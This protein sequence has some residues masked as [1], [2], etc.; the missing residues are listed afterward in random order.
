MA[1]LRVFI[2]GAS[3]GI[4]AA[5]AKH[6]ASEGAVLGLVSRRMSELERLAAELGS[7]PALYA[8]DVG[9]A[10]RMRAA[11]HDFVSRFGAPDVVIANAGISVG[12]LGAMEDDIGVLDRILRT[13]V[14]GLA[15]TLQPF[16]DPMLERGSG[17]LVTIASIAGFRGLPG[18][19][20]YSASK[21]A[22]ITWTESLRLELHKTPLR[23]LTICPGFVDTPMTKV[24]THPMPFMLAPDE[25]ARRAARTIAAD[26]KFAV[27]PWQMGVVG[28]FLK[29][30]P[31][32]LYDRALASAARKPRNLPM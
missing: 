28:W 24:N 4:G 16:V 19:G 20:A 29:R 25:F 10:A 18:S 31:R 26:R 9:D 3:S 22:A 8:A 7:S 21:S 12:T 14:L 32:W 5:L 1:A 6:Y 2:T 17:T 30:L 13:N 23:V 27:I 11:A 15:T